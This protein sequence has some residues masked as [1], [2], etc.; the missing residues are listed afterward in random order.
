MPRPSLA[1][2]LA[3]LAAV[4]VIAGACRTDAPPRST[5]PASPAPT[6]TSRE[7]DAP[8]PAR[9]RPSRP[10]SQPAD[11]NAEPARLAGVTA[12]HNRVR[13]RLGIAPLTWSSELA[14]FAQAW[15]DKLQRRGC[16]LQHRPRSGPDKQRHGENIYSATGQRSSPGDVVDAWAEEVKD[17]DAR[18]D[19]CRGICGHYTQIVWR[20]SQRLG[21]AMATCGA[22]EVWVCNYDP[23]GNFLGERPY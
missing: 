7:P 13:E 3:A 8:R 22:T 18:T 6:P 19:R 15:A 17:Y 2:H 21:C 11:A 12:A 20:K 5:P 23:P 10:K 14:Q 16:E 1:T 9:A 4:V